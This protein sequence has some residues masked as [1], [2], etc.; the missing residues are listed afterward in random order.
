MHSLKDWLDGSLLI[1]MN[2]SF[3]FKLIAYKQTR[4]LSYFFFFSTYE[5][6][7]SKIEFYQT[8]RKTSLLFV[9][10]INFYKYYLPMILSNKYD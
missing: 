9:I 10:V 5:L 6:N 3:F 2:F 7:Y 8:N 1:M 4:M